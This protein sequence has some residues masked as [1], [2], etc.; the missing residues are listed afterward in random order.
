LG[1]RYALGFERP[2]DFA[3]LFQ[4]AREK[5]AEGLVVLASGQISPYYSSQI[6]ELATQ[7]KFPT[8]YPTGNYVTQG[9]LMAYGMDMVAIL[10]R[11]ACYVDRILKGAGPSELPVEQPTKVEFIINLRAAKGIGLTIPPEVLYRTD[12]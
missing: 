10:R 2:E 7:N 11:A 3:T 5:R 12:K 4:A 9:G 1:Y 8:M 6:V